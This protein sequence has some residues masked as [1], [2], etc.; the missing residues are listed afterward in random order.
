MITTCN[1]DTLGYKP[2]GVQSKKEIFISLLK[3]P[4]V[5]SFLKTFIDSAIAQSE[6]QILKRLAALEQ[7]L[8]FDVYDEN[9]ANS[10]PARLTKIEDR[11]NNPTLS[12]EPALESPIKPV[13]K[14]QKRACALVSK[15]R[16][17]KKRFLTSSEIITFLKHEVPEDLRVT[18]DIRNPREIKREVLE[19]A[20][21]IFPDVQLS[22]KSHGRREVR[23]LV[24]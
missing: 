5:Q 14:T 24:S 22:K 3:E 12:L 17:C 19:K 10:I 6:L 9:Q 16:Q 1:S 21:E 8:G 20:I 15:L 23:I 13:T 4:E 2:S 7:V 18:E 11:M